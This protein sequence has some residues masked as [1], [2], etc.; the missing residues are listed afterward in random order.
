MW[1]SVIDGATIIAGLAAAASVFYLAKQIKISV[2]AE[3]IKKAHEFLKRYNDPDFRSSA[4]SIVK[5]LR[6]ISDE[7]K[8]DVIKW[9]EI[10]INSYQLW[11]K[12]CKIKIN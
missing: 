3:K 2:E 8:A 11:A 12:I 9:K 1:Q 10:T 6:D 5:V 4:P 7:N